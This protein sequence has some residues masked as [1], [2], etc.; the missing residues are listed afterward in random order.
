MDKEKT[1]NKIR[2]L[3]D[4]I[5]NQ[6]AAG[7]VVQRPESV[8]K[9]L[10]ENSL[11]AGADSIAVVV[12]GA[13]KQLIHII[14]NG[15]G[16]DKEDLALSVKRHATSKII[17]QEDLETIM[18]YGFRGEALASI[19]SVAGLEIRTKRKE[20]EVG[21]KLVS[22]PMK[23]AVIEPCRTDNGTQ[24]FVK[25]LFYN[26]PA[27]RKFLRANLTEFRY[28][29][30]TMIK[31]ALSK[32]KVRFTFYDDDTLIFD[33]KSSS[34]E[35]RIANILG[36]EVKQSLVIVGLENE[37]IRITGFTGTPNTAKTSR[38]HQYFFL[39]GRSIISKSL[40]HAVYSA[41][42]TILEKNQ[43]PFFLLNM[44]IDP[45]NI[46]IN[47]H[48]Q[49][50]EVKFDNERFVYNAVNNAVMRGLQKGNFIPL[51]NI[52][53]SE[54]KM[55]FIR[56]EDDNIL[57]NKNTGEIVRS[58]NEMSRFSGGSGSFQ[59][60]SFQ[61]DP[62]SRGFNQPERSSYDAIFGTQDQEI[63]TENEQRNYDKFLQVH[64][65]YITIET[66]RAVLLIDQ[67]SAHTR[68]LYEKTLNALK[69]GNNSSQQLLYPVEC[70]L[71]VSEEVVYKEIRS[72]LKDLGYIIEHKP[73]KLII[74]AV[75]TEIKSG[76]EGSSLKEIL[77][78]FDENPE[79]EMAS[80]HEKLAYYYALKVA[81]P[82]NK[83]LSD[84]E[85]KKLLADLFACEQPYI[86]PSGKPT[87]I[88]IGKN[89][90]EKRFSRKI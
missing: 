72:D 45:R 57:I 6:I 41:Y 80:N 49:K 27:R 5:A 85:I 87:L 34:I 22:D 20:D 12:K 66:E 90:L 9:E 84:G 19:A 78:S 14:D 30:D 75:P 81:T 16:M 67:H 79:Q 2:I 86:T 21:W 88:E 56:S 10:V 28:I 4:F 15:Y 51:F 55:P 24:I 38:T 69:K 59:Q 52:E 31:F 76:Q 77:R 35:D 54:S 44:E 74:S 43:Y 62:D 50:H 29:S 47:V 25:N 39:N 65:T 73:E 71:S 8:V 7:E 1:K 17:S 42:D 58:Q 60:R 68:V 13:G 32:P 40:S 36:E 63:F 26:V 70:P 61:R 83:K 64:N 3:P 53:E 11:D 46:D 33:A 82:R 37:D 23:E 18:S 48:P 89:N